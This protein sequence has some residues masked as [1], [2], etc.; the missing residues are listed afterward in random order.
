MA[1]ILSFGFA[2]AQ[3]AP[4]H[5][6]DL[7]VVKE[8]GKAKITAFFINNS[9]DDLE[10]LKYK[11]K[12][13]RKGAAG[14]SSSNQGGSFSAKANEKVELSSSS[15]SISKGDVY[16]FDLVV[17]DAEGNTIAEKTITEKD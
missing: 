3:S 16:T 8:E 14:T 6:A 7:Q 9:E 15:V 17:L 1:A 2:S 5:E 12:V 10:N 4:K 11:L 13:E